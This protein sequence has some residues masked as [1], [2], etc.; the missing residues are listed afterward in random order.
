MGLKDTINNNNKESNQNRARAMIF[1]RHHLHEA[2]KA[3]Y[4]TVK[5]LLILWNSLKEKFDH[6]KLLHL[7][8]QDYKS[9][10]EYNSAMFRISSQMKLYGEKITKEDMLE[11]MFS[12]FHALNILLQQQY[13][14]KVAEQN[15]ELLM[16]N[17]ETRP[18]SSVPIPEVNTAR[19]NNNNHERGRGRGR[20]YGCGSKYM[21]SVKH[22]EICYRCGIEGIGDVPIVRPNI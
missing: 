2:L 10:N 7:R 9:I 12:T 1:F 8:L 19:I 17:H 4:L 22:E 15:N 14:E 20:R 21:T 16:K 11:K 5:G 18:T 6:L 3:E 13:R